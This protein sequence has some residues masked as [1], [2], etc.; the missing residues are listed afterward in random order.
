[1]HKEVQTLVQ[2][3]KKYRVEIPFS[4]VCIHMRISGKIGEIK[5][6]EAK[7]RAHLQ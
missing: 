1:M 4:E 7:R 5:L 2:S 3:G 6:L